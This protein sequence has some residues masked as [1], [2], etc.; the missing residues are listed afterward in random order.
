MPLWSNA[1]LRAREEIIK[2]IALASDLVT[3]GSV[4]FGTWSRLSAYPN[5]GFGKSTGTVKEPFQLNDA[6]DHD[7]RL[8][9]LQPEKPR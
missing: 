3:R 2:S 1:V 8:R 6:Q 5:C 7:D 4:K 9:M